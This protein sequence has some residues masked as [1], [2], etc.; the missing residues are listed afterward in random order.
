MKSLRIETS[1]LQLRP[2]TLD[3]VDEL[4]LLWTDP[5]VRKYLWDDQVIPRETTR[6]IIE[7]SVTSFETNRF[8]L[9]AVLPQAK[10]KL[11]GF[12]A[13]WYFREPPQLELLYGL[14]PAHWN[15]GLGTEVARALITYGFEELSFERIDASTDAANVESARVMEKVG[16]VLQKRENTNGLDT[17]YYSISRECYQN[18]FIGCDRANY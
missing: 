4:H 8:G 15:K 14:S 11:V 16:M 10:E 2:F 17:V 13:F 12:A 3:D 6:A 1:R 5:L 18:G 9:W 7:N